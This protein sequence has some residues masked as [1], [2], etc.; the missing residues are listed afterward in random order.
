MARKL[1]ASTA[2]AALLLAIAAPAGAQGREL[3]YELHL[4]APITASAIGLVVGSELLKAD[5]VPDH[6]RWCDRD[7]DRDAL[8]FLDRGARNAFRWE[9]R[10]LAAQTSDVLG[11]IASP[12][13][14]FGG[15]TIAA[16]EDHAEKRT[17]VDV[18]IVVECVAMSAV[19]NQIVKFVVARERPYAHERSV[20]G[21]LEPPKKPDDNL[22]FWS[23]H[24]SLTFTLAAAG[25]AVAALG[26][27][28]HAPLVMGVSGS[29]ALATGYLRIAAD[30]H[31]FTDVLTGAVM[32]S[33]MGI[34]LPIVFHGRTSETSTPQTTA[35]LT[36]QA[37]SFG[38]SF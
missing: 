16:A 5:L 9:D 24:T 11:F 4:D 29:L 14:S 30:K 12:I 28:D 21:W 15:L 36:T 8:D 1:L 18:L 26:G 22:S 20:S 27:Y 13:L 10:K 19:L 34:L 23:G 25:G 31:Y 37:F 38:S 7:G 35:P 3:R 32:G 17:P 2:T 33:A 6:C